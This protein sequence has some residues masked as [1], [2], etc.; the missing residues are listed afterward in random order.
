[1]RQW[2]QTLAMCIF[3]GFDQQLPEGIHPLLSIP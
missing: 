3:A 2:A 1:M